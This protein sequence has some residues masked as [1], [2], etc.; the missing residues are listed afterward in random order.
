MD[1]K[2]SLIALALVALVGIVG[3]TYAYFTSKATL[4]NSFKT[5]TY[6][7][8]V[9]EEFVSPTNWAPGQ[10]VD[11]KVNVTN[12][13]TVDIAVRASYTESW[14]SASGATLSNTMDGGDSIA[15]FDIGADW[16]E[17]TDGKYYYKSTLAPNGSTTYFIEEVTFNPDYEFGTTD[18]SCTT[19][20][21][22]GV[23]EVKCESLNTGYAGATYK[24][25]I[26][27]ETIQADQI[28]TYTAA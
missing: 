13:G 22:D 3:G 27:I 2:K 21:V 12:N 25:D 8:S 18:I 16:I 10:T 14:T 24:L 28:W 19:T 20:T 7:T 9:T 11:K 15:V 1:T 6:A 23:T 5:G 26:T 4:N 17:A